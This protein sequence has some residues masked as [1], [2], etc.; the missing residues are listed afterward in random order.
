MPN[1]LHTIHE[2]NFCDQVLCSFMD[3]AIIQCDH[4]Q[5]GSSSV[6]G[7]ITSGER[8]SIPFHGPPY[9]ILTWSVKW[10]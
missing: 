9:R 2:V 5:D 4:L 10:N 6:G 3:Q 1:G 8:E 7:K